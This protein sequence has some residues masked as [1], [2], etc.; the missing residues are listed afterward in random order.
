M[1]YHVFIG[2]DISKKTIDAAIKL[3][4]QEQIHHSQFRNSNEGFKD[5]IKWI[6]Q[7]GGKDKSSWLFCM[8]HTGV[9][10]LPLSCFLSDHQFSFCLENPY[11]IKH[12]MGLQRGKTDKKDAIKIA[13]YAFLHREE[14]KLSR[15][16]G[17]T[18]IKLQALLS[19]RDRLINAQKGFKIAS[20]ELSGFVEKEI[21]S[22]IQEDTKSLVK[23][24]EARIKKVEIQIDSL[25]KEDVD[26]YNNYTLAKS[27]KG[28]G[29]IIAAYMIMYTQNFTSITESRKFASF[30]GI[31]PFESS[32]GSSLNKGSS[33]S[34]M[35][36]KKMKSLL[37]SGAW[38]AALSDNELKHYFERK[39]KEGKNKLS[40]INAIRNKLVGRVFAVVKR[41]TPYVSIV[42]YN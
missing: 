20:G 26:V 29:P 10:V 6:L 11:H 36:N 39:V 5:M 34:H 3:Q 35:A 41:G 19:Y 31:A 30:S 40:I 14:L 23:D 7:R 33:V 28:I 1:N 12:S 32:S 8:E 15:F 18:M 9:Y 22:Q 38:S 16:Q 42:N 24:I 13:R 4:D 17:K 37:N 25:L 27:V 21:S 2:V